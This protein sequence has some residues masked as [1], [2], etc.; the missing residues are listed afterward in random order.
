MNVKCK[1]HSG[2]CFSEQI[3]YEFEFRLA[4]Y[5][6][7]FSAY[8]NLGLM[9]YYFECLNGWNVELKNSNC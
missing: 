9:S 4:I 7:A 8:G 2:V 1:G 6:Q 5:K 3:N